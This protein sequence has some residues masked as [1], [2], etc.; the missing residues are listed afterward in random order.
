[1]RIKKNNK[2]KTIRLEPLSPYTKVH[3]NMTEIHLYDFI[4]DLTLPENINNL[5]VWKN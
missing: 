2:N 5:D 4:I 3:H 1:M